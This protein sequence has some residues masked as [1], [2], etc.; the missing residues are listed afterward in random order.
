MCFAHKHIYTHYF[1]K[2]T[3]TPVSHMQ[4]SLYTVLQYV[5]NNGLQCEP[6]TSSN[7]S[8][9]EELKTSCSPLTLKSPLKKTLKFELYFLIIENT[10]SIES[11]AEV[12]QAADAFGWSV[13]NKS[14]RGT[15]WGNF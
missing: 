9:P 7:V 4:M 14:S 6:H 2:L 3:Q 1:D 11:K 12:K 13:V 10:R 15:V 5:W 8:A